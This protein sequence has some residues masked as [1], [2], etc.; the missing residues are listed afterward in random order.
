MSREEAGR[1]FVKTACEK[2]DKD[3]AQACSVFA[4]LCLG[5]IGG[6]QQVDT[7]ISL[8]T[9]LCQAPYNDARAC[10]KL[11]SAYIRGESAY[12]GVAQDF[13]KAFHTMKRACDELGHP[14]GCQALAV[15]Y[16]KGDG[17]KQDS[18]KA[19]QYKNLTSELLE[20]TGEKLGT[21]SIPAGG[22]KPN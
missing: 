7:A 14:N 11:G 13:Q 12:P 19:E 8:L 16:H 2:S 3:H 5:G 6:P 9:D 10:V 1:S 18:D 20:K 21:L 17:V 22:R 4:T 15:M